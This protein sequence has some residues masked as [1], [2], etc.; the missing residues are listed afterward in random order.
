MASPTSTTETWKRV[1]TLDGF[2]ER[3]VKCRLCNAEFVGSLTKVM[4]HLLSISNGKGGGVEGCKNV[5]A[6]LKE[7]LQKDYNG[8]KKAKKVNENKRQCIQEEIARNYN[9]FSSGMHAT[10]SSFQPIKSSGTTPLN[11][12][13]K[14]VQKQEVDDAVADMF[15]EFA[16]PI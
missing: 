10:G 9:P 4:D 15:F 7:T 12:L 14:P 11:S 3:H 16:N 6:E 8:I 2:N 1:E 13:W 5:S